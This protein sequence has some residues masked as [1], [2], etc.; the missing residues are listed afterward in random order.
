VLIGISREQDYRRVKSHLEGFYY[1]P[2]TEDDFYEAS[3]LGSS[4]RKKGASI[5]PTNIII[6]LSAIKNQAM[7]YHSDR[8]F[9]LI[10]RYTPSGP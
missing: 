3:L 7:L 8:H 9:E 5:P 4:L 1:L 6:A 10:A 2:L